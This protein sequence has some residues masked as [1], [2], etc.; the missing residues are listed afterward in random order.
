MSFLLW[1]KIMAIHYFVWSLGLQLWK[2]ISGHLC[3]LLFNIVFHFTVQI[4]YFYSIKMG[5][6]SIRWFL[7]A[8]FLA[9]DVNTAPIP[10]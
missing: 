9:T 7:K 5:K 3:F 2:C 6:M 8:E 4:D 10:S 1:H